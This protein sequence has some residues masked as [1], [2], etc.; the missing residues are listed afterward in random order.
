LVHI[1]FPSNSMEFT[2]VKE[3]VE[4]LGGHKVI[5]KILIANNGLAATKGIRSMRRW[6]YSTFKKLD[7]IKFVVMATPEDIK[8]NAEYIRLADE[9]IE[10]PGGGTLNNYSNVKLIVDLAERVGADA[11]WA[12]WGHASENPDL[13]DSLKKTKGNIVFVGPDGWSMKILGDKVA[14]SIVAETFGVPT[15]PWRYFFYLLNF[16]V[17]KVLNVQKI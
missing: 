3:Y 5:T 14:S 4:K 13:P 6:A 16:Q 10:V 15:L 2:S 17:V 8:A 9:L 12:G 11:V 1:V 7:A